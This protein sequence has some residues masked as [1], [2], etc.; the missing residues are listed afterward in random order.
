MAL[1]DLFKKKNINT[2][3]NKNVPYII[4]DEELLHIAVGQWLGI[5]PSSKPLSDDTLSEYVPISPKELND[6]YVIADQKFDLIERRFRKIL[7][8]IGLPEEEL[9]I[10]ENYNEEEFSFNCVLYSSEKS[11][12]IQLAFGVLLESNPELKVVDNNSYKIYEYVRSVNPENER[13]VL[14]QINKPVDGTNKHFSRFYISSCYYA[15]LYDKNNNLHVEI[16]Y[17]DSLIDSNCEADFIDVALMEKVISSI[18]FPIQIDEVCRKIVA[19]LTHDVSVYPSIIIKA[20]TLQDG[21][22]QDVT[23]AAKFVKGNFVEL[24]YT[25]NGKA[26]S[27]D[28]FNQ[29]AY[30]NEQKKTSDDSMRLLK[31]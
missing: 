19:A 24:L 26:V 17:P 11:I 12:K 4:F 25:K 20:S 3:Y 27:I 5:L 14:S 7:T 22:E 18:N 2:D 29:W 9:C 8:S 6:N 23:D 10:L 28:S 16:K 15:N 21:I 1:K 13:L 30:E 31:K